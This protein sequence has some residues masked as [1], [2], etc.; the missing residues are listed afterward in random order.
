MN[1]QEMFSKMVESKD[2]QTLKFE[3]QNS[4]STLVKIGNF[5]VSFFIHIL[6]EFT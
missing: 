3:F 5:R 1:I 6:L 4:L 2:K